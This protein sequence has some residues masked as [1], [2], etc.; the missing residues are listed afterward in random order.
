VTCTG[1]ACTAVA[2][3]WERE[4]R[5]YSVSNL[6]DGRVQLTFTTWPSVMVVVVEAY[7]AL[8]VAISEFELPYRAE[9]LD[10]HR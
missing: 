5:G 6:S 10:W 2:I 7:E 1:N 9:F 8:F 4:R 3:T